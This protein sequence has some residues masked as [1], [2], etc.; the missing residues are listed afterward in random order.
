MTASVGWALTV[1]QPLQVAAP[2]SGL[3]T[4]MSRVPTVAPPVADRVT[5]SWVADTKDAGLS[6][7]TPVPEI[8]TVAPSWKLVPVMVRVTPLAP[9]AMPAEIDVTVGAAFTERQFVQ[10]VPFWAPGW[11]TRR[12]A[13]YGSSSS[14]VRTREIA[15]SGGSSSKVFHRSGELSK[16]GNPQISRSYPQASACFT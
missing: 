6:R 13:S 8:V 10:A 7:V 14:D 11:S 4:V 2:S 1:R 15:R 5:E 12:C 9:W 3:V 16:R